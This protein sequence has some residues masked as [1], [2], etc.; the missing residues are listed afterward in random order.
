MF[1]RITPGNKKR[2]PTLV[3]STGASSSTVA[4]KRVTI[5]AY[6][7]MCSE[8]HTEQNLRESERPACTA[9]LVE[10]NN[11]TV[12]TR[13]HYLCAAPVIFTNQASAAT[14]T[15]SSNA[16]CE[17]LT[18]DFADFLR[19]EFPPNR[20]VLHVYAHVSVASFTRAEKQRRI[21]RSG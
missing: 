20:T 1:N 11:Y 12:P 10:N 5:F 6:A 16:A 4:I 14:C 18:N 19:V 13:V 9:A 3:Y 7:I 17:C 21:M 15:T 2:L 8:V